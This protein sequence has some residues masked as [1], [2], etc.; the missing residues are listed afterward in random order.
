MKY[1]FQI[2]ELREDICTPEYCC[3]SFDYKNLMDPDINAWLGPKG[4]VSPLHYD[5]KN[6]I[7]AQVSLKIYYFS[8]NKKK[9]HFRYMEQNR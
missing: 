6:N 7:L 8:I 3:L 2:T 1:I 9:H 5:P 4:T